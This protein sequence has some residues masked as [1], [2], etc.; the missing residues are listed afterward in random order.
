MQRC[1]NSS[2]RVPP[3]ISGVWVPPE[4]V[5]PR[6]TQVLRGRRL[7]LESLLVGL[8]SL[9]WNPPQQTSLGFIDPPRRP[10]GIELFLELPRVRW[11]H[12]AQQ[13]EDVKVPIIIT[14]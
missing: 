7:R 1:L 3:R 9:S 12:V 6:T 8:L 10:S 14:P 2:D 13:I 4:R 5:L 11:K